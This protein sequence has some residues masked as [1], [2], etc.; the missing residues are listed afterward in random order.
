MF[1][2][3]FVFSVSIFTL[4]TIER[5]NVPVIT[6][7]SSSIY[8]VLQFGFTVAFL[9]L[10]CLMVRYANLELRQNLLSIVA[11]YLCATVVIGL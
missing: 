7:L 4:E 10:I 11:Q 8:G 3:F 1:I 5:E 2:F 9:R 6:I